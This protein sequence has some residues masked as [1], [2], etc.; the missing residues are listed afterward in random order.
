M[1]DKITRNIVEDSAV[2]ADKIAANSVEATELNTSVITGQSELSAVADDDVMLIYDASTSGLKKNQK[3]NLMKLAVPTFTSVSP[4]NSQ[5]ADDG[6]ITFT[7]TGTGFDAGS[8]MKLI[9]NNGTRLEFDTV[10]R[11]NTT[12]MTGTIARSS[13]LVAQTPYDIQIRNGGGRVVL[14]ANAIDVD[15]IPLWVTAAGTL[16]SFLESEA[17]DITVTA[18]DPDSSSAVTFELQSGSLPPGLSLVNQTGDSCRITGTPTAVASDTTSNFTLR[19]YDSASNT[20]SRAFSITI[21]DFNLNGCRFNDGSSDR[22]QKDL[23]DG[24]DT[25]A[26]IS[27]WFKRSTHSLAQTLF[28]CYEDSSNYFRVRLEAS[29]EIQIR[30]RVGGSDQLRLKTSALIRDP[31]AWYSLI[32]VIDTTDGVAADR[33]KVYLN[34]TRVTA[35]GTETTYG[36]SDVIETGN[37]DSTVNLGGSGASDNYL[38]GYL[39]EVVFLDGTA[40][41]S[42]SFGESNSDGVWIP[43]NISGLTFGTNGFHCDFAD[44]ANLGNDKNG[45]TDL[46]EANLTSI[47]KSTDMPLNNFCTMNPIASQAGSAESGTAFTFA[48]GNLT[49]SGMSSETGIGTIGVANGKWFWEVK[50]VTD[51]DGLIIGGVNQHFHLDAELGY[52]TP[53]S[54]TGAKVFGYY[55]GNGNSFVTITDGTSVSYG[56]AISVNDIV[57]VALDLTSVDQTCT[58][59]LNGAT[60]GSLDITNLDTGDFYFPAVGN[61]SVATTATSFNFGSPPYSETGGNS[62]ANGYGNFS[63]SVPSGYFSLCTKNLATYG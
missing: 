20:A 48:D 9:S 49:L 34:G 22:L 24:H 23:S 13:L 10:V 2:N 51:Q 30:D 16:G 5:T 17:M 15:N 52:E 63:M 53:T 8:N 43:K 45:G 59:Y 19:A 47:D 38:D 31:A 27:L 7:V 4:D 14:G 57:S 55:G 25:A 54:A 11:T 26:T 21:L 28:E 6:N 3:S 61:W 41:A 46:T 42:S 32:I 36:S 35:F 39:S 40:Q 44:S 29:N 1:A 56:S 62:D 37:A 18:R 33:C 12:T 50:V 58:F 60:Q